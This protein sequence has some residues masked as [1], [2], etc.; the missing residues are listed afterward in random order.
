MPCQRPSAP[1]S[2]GEQRHIPLAGPWHYSLV[3]T[4]DNSHRDFASSAAIVALEVSRMRWREHSGDA[5]SQIA[6]THAPRYMMAG[7]IEQG[8]D[9]EAWIASVARTP[10]DQFPPQWCT[11]K[12]AL[13]WQEKLVSAR[14]GILDDPWLK[15]W[16]SGPH[17]LKNRVPDEY[18]DCGT[19]HEGASYVL[20][21]IIS[22]D[23]PEITVS[24]Q[25]AYAMCV[26]CH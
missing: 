5:W 3:P 7:P 6:P 15:S 13:N 25:A 10:T 1:S 22:A 12:A 26:D 16:A 21:G 23:A 20:T 8:A 2:P 4:M 17:G 9:I 14:D 11:G 18:I 19:G 24:S